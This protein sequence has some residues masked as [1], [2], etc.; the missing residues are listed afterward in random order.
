MADRAGVEFALGRALDACES[1]DAAFE[2]Y[3]AANR[4]SRESAG[5]GFRDYDLDLEERFVDRLIAA[6]RRL[7]TRFDG[8]SHGHRR[9]PCRP[10]RYSSAA[11]SARDQP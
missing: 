9:G 10:S 1:Y 3:R 8:A 11:C 2:V 4:H 6:F 5:P 7:P